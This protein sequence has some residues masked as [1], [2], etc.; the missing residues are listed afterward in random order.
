[1]EIV[2]LIFGLLFALALSTNE[3][4]KI[5]KKDLENED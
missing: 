3:Q 4:T 1:M 5:L 2:F